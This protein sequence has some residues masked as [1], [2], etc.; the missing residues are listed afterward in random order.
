MSIHRSSKRSVIAVTFATAATMMVVAGCSGSPDPQTSHAAGEVDLS[1]VTITL[2]QNDASVGPLFE[3]SGVLDDAPYNVEFATFPDQIQAAAALVSGETDASVSA[4]YVVVQAAA[5]A[6]PEWTEETVPYVTAVSTTR[7][8]S[9]VADWVGTVSS[10]ESGI[11]ELTAE[12]VRGKKWTTT[13][14][15]TNFLTLLQ[16][17]D[18]LDVGFDEIEWVSLSNADGALALLNNQVDL[19]S[20]AYS[21]YTD[22]VA[23]GGTNLL[24]GSD[25]G[26]GSPGALIVSTGS[27][28]DPA[29]AAALEDLVAR[30]VDFLYWKLTSPEEV[31]AV[32][33]AEQK[34]TPEAAA[35]SWQLFHRAL[36]TAITP[37]LQEVT[38][39]ISQLAFD[40][41]AIQ[42]IAPVELQ[43]DDQYAD[44]INGEV[45]RLNYQAAID[46]SVATY[47]K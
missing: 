41:G 39:Q 47:D 10:P 21:G 19:A 13:P 45:E 16:T 44:V 40:S 26:P 31:Q 24:S 42:R 25:V 15:A 3:A 23:A 18:Y 35:S 30:Y 8:S 2:G 33:V 5:A 20:G 43:F 36:P 27:Q 14:G 4:Q 37:E 11:T 34:L 32:L 46:E 29:K 38:Q 9:D 17:L 7:I 22:S 1:G 12:S 28:D 6:T